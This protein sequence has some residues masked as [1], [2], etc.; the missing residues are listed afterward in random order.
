MSVTTVFRRFH[1]DALERWVNDREHFDERSH[2]DCESIQLGVEL[3]AVADLVARAKNRPIQTLNKDFLFRFL[4]GI[5]GASVYDD[6]DYPRI[7]N[8]SDVA[9]A[10]RMMDEISPDELRE[11]Y[12]L[13]RLKADHLEIEEY[14]LWD[15]LGPNVLDDHLMPMFEQIKRF[16]H[17]AAERKQQ[18]VVS[19]F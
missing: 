8:A 12:D 16:F 1:D 19:W 18:V 9:R 14:G 10:S 15:A 6:G 3:L 5:V 7:I 11:V 2:P 13:D 4:V 17:R